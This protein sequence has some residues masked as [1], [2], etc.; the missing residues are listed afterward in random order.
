MK[1]VSRLLTAIERRPA[2][3]PVPPPMIEKPRAPPS[4]NAKNT[5]LPVMPKYQVAKRVDQACFSSKT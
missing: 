5:T 3:D 1:N 4:A 2:L